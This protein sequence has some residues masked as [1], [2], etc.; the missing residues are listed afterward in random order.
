[1]KKFFGFLIIIALVL[2]I[3]ISCNEDDN[4]GNGTPDLPG[5]NKILTDTTLKRLNDVVFKNDITGWIIGDSG[6]LLITGDGGESWAGNKISNKNLHGLFYMNDDNLWI[7]GEK[8]LILFSPDLGN[9]WNVRNS[10]VSD[11]LNSIVFTDENNGW[12]CG[13][14]KNGN[15]IILHT[16]N[17]GNSIRGWEIQQLPE[18]TF[19]LNDIVFMF[20]GKGFA[21]GEKGTII[22]T[23]DGENWNHC[24]VSSDYAFN[25]LYFVDI[26]VAYAVGDNGLYGYTF[27][28]GELWETGNPILDDN[29]NDVFFT[30]KQVGWIASNDGVM[31]ESL[32]GGFN[33][34]Q[35]NL[36]QPDNLNSIYFVNSYFGFTV[37]SDQF[38]DGV[39]YMYVP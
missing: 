25:S 3:N 34:I 14:D 19:G 39:V 16:N 37:G 38:G 27:N 35:F 30:T 17:K 8:G 26:K 11:D 29:L 22:K 9:T 33:W 5:W 4:N 15:G 21:V 31:L 36:D 23:D 6:T 2:S 18:E 12:I 32:N 10:P 28:S 24:D 1:M 7:V 13:E 20:E